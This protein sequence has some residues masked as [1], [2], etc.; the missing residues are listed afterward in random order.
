MI[1]INIKRG[2]S[3]TFTLTFTDSNNTPLDLSIYD[4]IYADLSTS[5]SVQTE[6]LKL[7]LGNGL[8]VTNNVLTFSLLP[9]QSFMLTSKKYYSD[10]KVVQGGNIT[11]L[12]KIEFNVEST[13]TLVNHNIVAPTPAPIDTWVYTI[14][15]TN[16]GNSATAFN[17]VEP[18]QFVV[19]GTTG[20]L[21]NALTGLQ[22]IEI[23]S[24]SNNG[25]SYVDYFAEHEV[26]TGIG[27][28]VIYGGTVEI[29]D[30]L[31][32]SLL[33]NVV[34]QY[35]STEDRIQL[36]IQYVSGDGVIVPG[37]DVQIIFNLIG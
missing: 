11:T 21:T 37:D 20:D 7:S 1:N 6:T 29:I 2:D 15:L 30:T 22:Y 36:D 8:S 12:V 33:Y 31:G 5:P 24:V 28:S 19:Y 4:A 27:A 3:S 16:T 13:S 14:D 34:G 26:V 23:S 10:V 32:N 35:Q 18:G 17:T 9:T 25:T